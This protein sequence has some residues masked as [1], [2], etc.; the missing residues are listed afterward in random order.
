MF[1][2]VRVS[3]DTAVFLLGEDRVG[4]LVEVGPT[5]EVFSSPTDERTKAYVAGHIG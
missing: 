1:Q 3:D 4:E 2:A 5:T